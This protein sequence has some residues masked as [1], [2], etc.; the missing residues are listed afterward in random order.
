MA[1]SWQAISRSRTHALTYQLCVIS[2]Y[3]LLGYL[4]VFEGVCRSYIL[5]TTGDLY[6]GVYTTAHAFPQHRYEPAGGT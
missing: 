5:S 3:V 4:R 6:T 2:P 1:F